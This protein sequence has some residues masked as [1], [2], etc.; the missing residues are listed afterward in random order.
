MTVSITNV[1]R[2]VRLA[3][4]SGVPLSDILENRNFTTLD[5]K[6]RAAVVKEYASAHEVEARPMD[7]K[8]RIKALAAKAAWGALSGAVAGLPVAMVVR[9]GFMPLSKSPK[10]IAQGLRMAAADKSVQLGVGLMAGMGGAQGAYNAVKKIQAQESDKQR[11]HNTLE[12][13]RKG[14]ADADAHAYG[15]MFGSVRHYD[16]PKPVTFANPV[17]NTVGQLVK[18]YEKAINSI[19]YGRLLHEA[20]ELDVAGM[21]ARMEKDLGVIENINGILESAR[22]DEGNPYPRE[23]IDQTIRNHY[24]PAKSTTDEDIA[25]AD[26]AVEIANKAKMLKGMMDQVNSSSI[27]S[28]PHQGL[29][30]HAQNLSKSD[31]LSDLASYLKHYRDS[32]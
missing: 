5:M 19:N 4:D 21:Q 30:E 29:A 25:N 11:V 28:E 23:M 17:I 13:I 22:D 9:S 16:D 7:T 24:S 14:G 3:R 26:K 18:P 20:D 2:G 32:Q 10:A 27:L 1:A 12:T 15:A 8:Q 6:D 31:T